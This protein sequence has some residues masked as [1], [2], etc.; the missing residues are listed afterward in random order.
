M[1]LLLIRNEKYI[2]NIVKM[3]F[4]ESNEKKIEKQLYLLSS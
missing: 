1:Y 4:K 3:F 2:Q